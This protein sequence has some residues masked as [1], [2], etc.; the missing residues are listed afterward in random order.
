MKDP[1][2]NQTSPSNQERNFPP[3]MA[4]ESDAGVSSSQSDVENY[5]VASRLEQGVGKLPLRRKLDSGVHTP[6]SGQVVTS[7]RVPETPVDGFNWRKYGQKLVKG[8]AF[9][10]SYYKCTHANCSARK[11][12][13]RS[14]DGHITEINY[15]SKHEHPKPPQNQ[16]RGPNEPSLTYEAASSGPEASETCLPSSVPPSQSI[17]EVA[18]SQSNEIESEVISSAPDAKRRKKESAVTKT[19]YKPRVVVTTTSPVDIVHDG[20]RW[21]KYGQKQVKGNP[22]PRSYYRCTN[23]GCPVRKQVERA[24]D[25][26]RVVVT[27]YEG[28]H[29][30]EMPSGIRT[31]GLNVQGN[32]NGAASPNDGEP[33]PQ[34]EAVEATGMGRIVEVGAD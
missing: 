5:S 28:S 10:R 22:N 3:V 25:D 29:D 24:S 21:R 11:Q 6:N 7:S 17:M 4:N 13:E 15:L 20:Y 2:F 27:T 23:D 16:E 1:Y 30:H 33:R 8:D 32:N 26:E 31:L 9:A 12:V 14:H 18:V 19:N 34:P